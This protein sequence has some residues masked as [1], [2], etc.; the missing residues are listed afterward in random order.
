MKPADNNVIEY[1]LAS[2]NFKGDG[3]AVSDSTPFIRLDSSSKFA[4]N[5]SGDVVIG[6]I[7]AKEISDFDGAYIYEREMYIPSSLPLWSFFGGDVLPDYDNMPDEE[8]YQAIDDLFMP[9]KLIQDALEK[10]GVDSIIP[11]FEERNKETDAA[12]YL[13]PGTTENKL[14][15]SL[16]NACKDENLELARLS[17]EF[18]NIRVESNKKLVSLIREEE[19][20]AIGFNYKSFSASQSYHLIFRRENGGWVLTR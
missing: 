1:Q 12:F 15:S 14:R 4:E 7:L 20:S 9:Y 16:V 19:M 10:G 18:L 17:S 2:I 6:E 11:M 13:E 8:Y 3:T 5:A